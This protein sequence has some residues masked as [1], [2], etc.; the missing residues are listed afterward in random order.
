[1]RA[2]IGR[3]LQRTLIGSVTVLWLG[4][5]GAVAWVVLHETDEIFNSSLQETSQRVLS[6]AIHDLEAT[7]TEG[8]LDISEPAAHDEYL[9]YQVFNRQ[10][11]MLMRSHGAPE[12]P[13]PVPLEAGHHVVGGQHFNVE[14]SSSGEYTIQ[15][16]ERAG[17]REETFSSTLLYLLLPLGALLPITAA[18]IRSS[19]RASLRA[20]LRF[21]QELATRSSRDLQALDTDNLPV[22]LLGL[23]E[24]VNSLLHR[25]QLALSAER[26]FTANSA[27]ELRT[28]IAAALAQLDVLRE[29]LAGLPGGAR[30]ATARKT[31]EGLECTTVKLLQLARAESGTGLRLTRMDLAGLVKMLLRDLSFRS[32]RRFELASP[33]QPVWI[34]GDVDAI[35][36]AIQNLLENAD[37]YAPPDTVVR[38]ELG[39]DG[40]LS[41]MNDCQ[42][43]PA[44]VLET[45]RDRFVRAAQ[46]GAGAGLGLSIVD[47]ILEQCQARLV[48]QSP[49]DDRGRGFAARVAFK[50][51]DLPT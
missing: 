44:P 36:I 1:M 24:S 11:H 47:T 39:P 29:E 35:G 20:I 19:V 4:V 10:G 27:H 46:V 23:G 48:L 3:K 17:H 6:L 40:G 45:L 28:P 32:E 51:R 14:S 43:I 25:L 8:R 30:V 26:S 22:E 50:S 37:R 12:Q 18:V 5:V 16:A 42:A 31:I 2:S 21:E 15:V 38:V 33:D 34:N 9:T 49:C 7:R 41:V 13:F